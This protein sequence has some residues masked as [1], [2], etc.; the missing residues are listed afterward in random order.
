VQTAATRFVILSAARTGSTLLHYMLASHPGV[1]AAG[2]I[3]NPVER[4]QG[5]IAWCDPS[6][7]HAAINTDENL[8]EWRET[9][10]KRFVDELIKA[11]EA[12]GGYQVIGFK[13]HYWD[14]LPEEAAAQ[15]LF[16]DTSIRVI[17][18]KRRNLLRQVVSYQRA[19]QTEQWVRLRG[20]APVE[21]PVISL[22]IE[23]LLPEIA[24]IEA[25]EH[26]YERGMRGHPILDLYYEDLAQ[27]PQAVGRQ[28]LKFLGVEPSA[29]LSI[30]TEKTNADSLRDAIID[31]DELKEKFQ[32]TLRRYATFFED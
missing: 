1:F 22:P 18:L 5:V 20:Q 24:A 2:E 13:W 31:Y 29:E 7:P 28:V 19:L 32:A 14:P 27:D 8:L 16:A 30:L 15:H 12:W 21:L 11:T 17:H 6:D 23:K 25:K 4:K 3:F 9:E 10:P 26:E